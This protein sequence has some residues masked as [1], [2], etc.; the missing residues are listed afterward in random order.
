MSYECHLSFVSPHQMCH[1]PTM[2]IYCGKASPHSVC[3]SNLSLKSLEF[4]LP[5]PSVSPSYDVYC[6]KAS[7]PHQ[8]ALL[9]FQVFLLFELSRFSSPMSVTQLQSI[10]LVTQT[11]VLRHLSFVSPH[12]ISVTLQGCILREGKPPLISQHSR[13][14]P[15][16]TLTQTLH[17]TQHN[18]SFS[19]KD[20]SVNQTMF[21]LE[22]TLSAVVTHLSF[23]FD[24]SKY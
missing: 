15:Q 1:P 17:C 18:Q 16:C 7:P 2:Y 10:L 5:T 24:L 21:Y 13:G 4:C 22:Q 23:A 20:I 8:S 19:A 3:N 6:G 14:L 11:S 9:S 12:H